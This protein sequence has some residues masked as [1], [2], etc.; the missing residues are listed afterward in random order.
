MSDLGLAAGLFGGFA[1]VAAGLG[2][3]FLRAVRGPRAGWIAA[4]VVLVFFV[5]LGGA[6]LALLPDLFAR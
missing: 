6:L 1:L 2:Y 5:L 3:G 4:A